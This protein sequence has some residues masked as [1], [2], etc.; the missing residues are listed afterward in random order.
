MVSLH[1]ALN[2][3]LL[4]VILECIAISAALLERKRRAPLLLRED[5][6][7]DM[8]R[9]RLF[10]HKRP[11]M[12]VDEPHFQNNTQFKACTLIMRIPAVI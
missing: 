4:N 5:G 11:V 6:S 12:S 9:L 2:C 1:K 10:H 7:L 3:T 8:Q